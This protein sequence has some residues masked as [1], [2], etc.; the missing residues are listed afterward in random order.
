MQ[1]GM[2]TRS[3][4]LNLALDALM[5]WLRESTALTPLCTRINRM[6]HA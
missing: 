4:A 6:Q 1:E 2:K 5:D 3:Q